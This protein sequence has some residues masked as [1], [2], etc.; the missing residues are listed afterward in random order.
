MIYYLLCRKAETTS[1]IEASADIYTIEN[2]QYIGYNLDQKLDRIL[3][4]LKK[5][6]LKVFRVV[7]LD[8]SDPK[9]LS[10]KAK[11][12]FIRWVFICDS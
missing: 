9:D 8:F 3:E 5:A 11:F 4:A 1:P 2:R 6:N 10:S 12:T 7:E